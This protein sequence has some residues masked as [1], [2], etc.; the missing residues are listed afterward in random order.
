MDSNV[1]RILVA[2]VIGA[3]GVGHVLG[4]LPAVGAVSFAGMS[5]RSWLLDGVVGDG[6]SRVMA[7]ALF[8]IPTFGFVA[9]A[10]GLLTG[11][12]WWRQAAV[13]SAAVSLMATAL[14]PQAYGTGST[15]GAVAV[16]AALLGSILVAG[17]GAGAATA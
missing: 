4:W 16:N 9:A 10:V 3:H 1:I 17:W 13:V 6:T 7:A 5:G 15:V 8:M 2:G 12:P 11:Q 14:Y